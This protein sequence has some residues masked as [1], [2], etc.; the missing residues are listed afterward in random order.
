[1]MLI[2]ITIELLLLWL[3]SRQ[4]TTV[5]FAT[6]VLITRSRTLGVTII[7]AVLYPG[8][9]LH[10]LSHLLSATFLGVKTGKM[11]LTPDIP[12]KALLEHK[13]VSIKTGSVDI[14]HTDIIRRTI[15]GIAP[16]LVG[17]AAI[18]GIALYLWP[19]LLAT[20]TAWNNH[21]SVLSLGY[22]VLL[23]TYFVWAIG[24]TMFPSRAD[25]SGSW[26]LGVIGL[27][28]VATIL[29]AGLG[30]SGTLPSLTLPTHPILT[31]VAIAV[32]IVLLLDILTVVGCNV[33]LML[34]L[35]GR[36]G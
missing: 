20:Q 3:L 34:A 30:M 17:V 2:V 22:F 21:Q 35:S 5:I 31:P 4:L 12:W 13:G 6:V 33:L 10:E 7:T 36:R 11:E 23:L 32:G 19:V 29:G 16:L 24:N 14:E 8:T 25:L 28:L 18:T 9:V 27:L 15:V 26:Q 1:M